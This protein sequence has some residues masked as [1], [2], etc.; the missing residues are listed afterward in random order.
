MRRE[1]RATLHELQKQGHQCAQELVGLR[2]VA[3]LRASA[4]GAHDLRDQG[5]KLGL[6]AL[7]RIEG[8]LRA[9]E[10]LEG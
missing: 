8:G 10:S 5:P 6:H 4:E 9:L 1:A 3:L 2:R 7:R